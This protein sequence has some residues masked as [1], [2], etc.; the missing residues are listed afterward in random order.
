MTVR[1]KRLFWGMIALLCIG[2]LCFVLLFACYEL[3]FALTE[4]IAN[5]GFRQELQEVEE[6]SLSL[7][8]L[9]YDS[10]LTE[11]AVENQSLMLINQDFPL[12]ERFEGDISEYKESGVMMNNCVKEAYEALSEDVFQKFDEKLYIMSAFRTEEQQRQAMSENGDTAA[13]VGESEHQAGLALDVYVRYYAGKGF[14]KSESGKYVNTDC[15][16]Y[17]FIIRYPYYGQASTGMEYE[18]WH[19]RYVGS[20]HAEI[21]YRNRLTLEK[22]IEDMEYGK[23]YSYGN[24]LITRQYPDHFLAPEVYQSVNIS[25][26]NCGGYILTFLMAGEK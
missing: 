9:T 5:L 13:A 26:D 2:T 18:P 25:P 16:K 4:C 7:R 20:P 21:I 22:Y 11:G 14:L 3:R 8:Q 12:P 17:G 6:D 10:L 23:F 24:Y 1:K 19:I 15:W